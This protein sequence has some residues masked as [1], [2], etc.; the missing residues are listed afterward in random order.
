MPEMNTYTV[1][2]AGPDAEYGLSAKEVIVG[3]KR[4][5]VTR[6]GQVESIF[7]RSRRSVSRVLHFY[8]PASCAA[9]KASGW[10]Q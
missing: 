3:G 2:L 9:R 5:R 10:F 6:S 8:G 7:G 1:K 4:Y